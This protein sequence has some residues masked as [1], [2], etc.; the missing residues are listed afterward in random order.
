MEGGDLVYF[1]VIQKDLATTNQPPLVDVLACGM[2]R[3]GSLGNA[4][5]S[6]AQSS[7]VKVKTV[8]GI[9]EC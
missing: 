9:L 3:W 5:F 2:G 4:Q 6:H 8:S 1:T 7:P